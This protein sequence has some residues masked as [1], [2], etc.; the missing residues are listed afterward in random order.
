MFSYNIC[1]VERH[2]WLKYVRELNCTRLDYAGLSCNATN[3]YRKLEVDT[4]YLFVYL[5]ILA[6]CAYVTIT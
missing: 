5:S 3:H 6:H 1:G 2:T 4:S